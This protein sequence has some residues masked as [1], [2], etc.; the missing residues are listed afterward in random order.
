MP[1]NCVYVLNQHLSSLVA[2]CF[3]LLFQLLF[4][5][6]ILLVMQKLENAIALRF[7]CSRT[8]IF[9]PWMVY[10][11][12]HLWKCFQN[13]FLFSPN[14]SHRG[15]H[16]FYPSPVRVIQGV[17]VIRVYHATKAKPTRAIIWVVITNSCDCIFYNIFFSAPT[18][19][20]YFVSTLVA[21]FS[22]AINLLE[23]RYAS[24]RLE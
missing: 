5:H 10:E 16:I 7:F 21:R 20:L 4:W 22:N 19:C 18:L 14:R 9:H 11:Y 15:E 23:G 17:F 24:K 2:H 13:N 1:F 8:R 12:T 3:L 6:A